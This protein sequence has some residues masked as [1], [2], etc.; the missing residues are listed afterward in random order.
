MCVPGWLK[1]VRLGTAWLL[2]R[3]DAHT[4]SEDAPCGTMSVPLQP[5]SRSIRAAARCRSVGYRSAVP[6][7]HSTNPT[8][9]RSSA[10]PRTEDACSLETCCWSRMARTI[11]SRSAAALATHRSRS[12]RYSVAMLE[13]KSSMYSNS[14]FEV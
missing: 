10:Y 7:R 5:V 1:D 11:S 8:W 3:H 12:V 9:Y 4:H 2:D 14:R 13:A 6:S